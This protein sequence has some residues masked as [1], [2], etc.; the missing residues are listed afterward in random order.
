MLKKL[1]KSLPIPYIASN[2]PRTNLHY[3]FI[4]LN[5]TCL[6]ILTVDTKYFIPF[7]ITCLAY[8]GI[9]MYFNWG[10]EEKCRKRK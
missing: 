2:C 10:K 7:V 8:V 4:I 5:L 9:A 1:L 3:I 6:Y